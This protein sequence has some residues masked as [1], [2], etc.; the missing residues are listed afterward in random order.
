MSS[1]ADHHLQDRQDPFERVLCPGRFVLFEKRLHAIEL[2]QQLLEPQLVHLMNDD[3]EHLVVL[4]TGRP[5]LLQRQELFELQIG[6]VGDG[7]A[8]CRQPCAPPAY[9]SVRPSFKDGA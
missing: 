4:G 7:G 2:V 8:A 5:R 6:A 3:E 1:C 9:V